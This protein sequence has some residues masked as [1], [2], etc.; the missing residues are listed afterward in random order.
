MSL[1]GGVFNSMEASTSRKT[2]FNHVFSTTEEGKAEVI[3]VLQYS[4]LG[5]VPIVILNKT[6]QRFIPEADSDKSTL[7]IFVEILVQLIIMF[8]GIV[9]I[10]RIIT[11]I[12]T[13]SEFKYESLS[14]TNVILAFLVVVLSIQTKLG[15]KVNILIDRLQEL[16]SGNSINGAAPVQKHRAVASVAQS[17]HVPSQGDHL[18]TSQDVFPPAPMTTTQANPSYDTMMRGNPAANTPSMIMEPMAANTFGNFSS[19]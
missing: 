14:L 6:I 17:N 12:P 13:Y 3:N 5:V 16:W 7:E 15:I 2:F 8:V 1:D 10:H 4:L 11:Y 18:G 19:F 9:I